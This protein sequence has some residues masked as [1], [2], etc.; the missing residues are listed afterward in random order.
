MNIWIIIISAVITTIGLI[1]ITQF[2]GRRAARSVNKILGFL[3]IVPFLSILIKLLLSMVI[4]PDNANA[5]STTAA[6]QMLEMLP[7]SILSG[8]I[9]DVA[10]IVLWGLYRRIKRFF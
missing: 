6:N 5:A 4:N 3:A 10:G 8:Y 7:E 1:I 9:G 2:M